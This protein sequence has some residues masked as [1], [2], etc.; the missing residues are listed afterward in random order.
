MPGEEAKESGSQNHSE[1]KAKC[2][3]SETLFFLQP[4]G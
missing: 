1:A 4:Q 2:A 3:L